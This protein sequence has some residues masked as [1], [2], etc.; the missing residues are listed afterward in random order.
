MVS[1]EWMKKLS[2]AEQEENVL[3]GQ[4]LNKEKLYEA[5]PREEGNNS[6]LAIW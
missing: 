6:A 2:K 5:H 4:W 1:K 3:F